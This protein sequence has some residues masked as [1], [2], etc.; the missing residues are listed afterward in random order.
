MW[1][2]LPLWLLVVIFVAAAG[3]VWAAGVSLST[4]T[5]LLDSRL[6]LS[7]A[8]GGL[9][10]LAVATNL[11]E[12][13][14]TV[15]A[16]LQHR[17]DLAIG[18]ILGGIAL[19][20][21]V[22]AALDAF[23]LGRRVS[24][25]RESRSLTLV[26]EGGLVVAVLM[27]VLMGAELPKTAVWGRLEPGSLLVVLV[28][29][30]GLWLIGK[31]RLSWQPTDKALDAPPTVQKAVRRQKQH[32]V[33]VT[34]TRA[35][36]TFVFAALVTLGAGWVLA[37]S[38]DAVA[39]HLHLSGVLFGATVLAVVTSLPELSTGLSAVRMGSIELAVSDIFGGNAFLPTLFLVASLLSGQPVLPQLQPS[40]VYLTALGALLT[41]VYIFGLV[42]RRQRQWGRMGPDSWTVIGFYLI[43]LVGLWLL[44]R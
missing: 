6:K 18:N 26:L 27:V 22:L 16:A 3:A 14:I 7:A 5:D 8:L 23:G 2:T 31:S 34:T 33:G 35:A 21:V 44:T 28:W 9:I 10:L 15:S 32:N 24:L 43:G 40:D 38:G 25:S 19:Q 13:A 30:A 20:T 11:P 37:L 41:T 42:T 29:G 1:T 4:T 17:L 36:L 39:Q 12:I